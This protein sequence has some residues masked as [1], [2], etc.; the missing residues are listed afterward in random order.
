[1]IALNSIKKRIFL[2]LIFC[3]GA[4]LGLAFLAKKI[5]INYLPYLGY[6]LMFPALGFILIYMFG[7]RKTGRETFGARI[8]WNNLRPI[9]GMFY[10]L[11]SL[12][13]IKKDRRCWVVLLLDAVLGLMAFT[14]HHFI[15]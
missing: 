10:L 5:D 14:A 13:A 1:M 9:H 4:R 15:L 3:M 7:L 11:A 6:I 2:F 8:W 12:M